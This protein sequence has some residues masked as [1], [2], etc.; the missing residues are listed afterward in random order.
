MTN[1][2]IN[3]IF[4][5]LLVLPFLV[6]YVLFP[7]FFGVNTN[8]AKTI[9]A[10]SLPQIGGIREESYYSDATYNNGVTGNT[11][12][13][14]SDVRE[15]MKV[16]YSSTI[17]SYRNVMADAE[18]VKEAVK[19]NDG[20]V[21][22]FS[23]S[24]FSAQIS[25]LVPKSKLDD[26]RKKIKNTI[27]QKLIFE[28]ITETNLLGE[29]QNL[30]N[31]EDQIGKEKEQADSYKNLAAKQL[32]VLNSEKS[33]LSSLQNRVKN[34]NSYDENY[35]TVKADL[36]S[37]IQIAKTKVSSAQGTYNSYL[38]TFQ[39]LKDINDSNQEHLNSE[40]DKFDDKLETVSGN[41]SIRSVDTLEYVQKLYPDLYYLFHPVSLYLLVLIVVYLIIARRKKTAIVG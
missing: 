15:F 13:S 6:Y 7:M 40:N 9:T 1:K 35:Y 2:K 33:K 21:N 11:N 31:R 34:L 32:T 26:F 4:L 8:R 17:Y 12:E 23:S 16:F 24:D 28:N 38:S 30:E 18:L 20:R 10:P 29:K 14:I 36:E 39:N 27:N 25:F 22:N 3:I 41:I 5:I 19:L 37:Q